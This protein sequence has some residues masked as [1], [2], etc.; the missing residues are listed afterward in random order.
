MGKAITS[1]FYWPVAVLVIGL[2]G[3]QVILPQNQPLND[4]TD[5]DT[6][7]VLTRAPEAP[8]APAPGS[9]YTYATSMRLFDDLKAYRPGDILTVILKEMTISSKKANT[10][11]GK[12]ATAS[13]APPTLFGKNYPKLDMQLNGNRNFGGKASTSQQNHLT[14]SVTV[15]VQ[16]VLPSGAL[17]V[18]GSKMVR[19]NQGDEIIFV[20][21]VVRPEDVSQDNQVSSLRL[22]QA[23]I[24]YTG[25][26]DLARANTQGWLSRILNSS[27]F[28]F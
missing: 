22:A 2:Q 27:W 1:T 26:G 28:P 11:L 9:L 4:S 13:I 18:K 23:K 19:I 16:K 24:S 7:P 3:C 5:E 10:S 15:V 21:G 20:S 6:E 25:R 12:E 17:L 14:G 8:P